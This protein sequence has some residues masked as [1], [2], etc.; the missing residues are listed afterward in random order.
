MLRSMKLAASTAGLVIALSFPA[1]AEVAPQTFAQTNVD[2]KVLSTGYRTSKVIGSDV[3]NKA[4]ENIGT[5]D[6][7]IITPNDKVPFAVLSVGGFLG[8]GTKYV[9]VSYNTF[10][11]KDRKMTLADATKESLKALPE[12]KY[13]K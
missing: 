9:V 3:I 12:F 8:V 13:G 10:E 11:I 6:D 5:I 7:L 2:Q 4:G 1:Y